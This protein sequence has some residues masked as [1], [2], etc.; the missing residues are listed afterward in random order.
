MRTHTTCFLIAFLMIGFGILPEALAQDESFNVGLVEGNAKLRPIGDYLWRTPSRGQS[1]DAGDRLRVRN[2]RLEVLFPQ[3]LVRMEETGEMEIPV[4]LTEGIPEPWADDVML[5]IGEYT[6]QHR[7]E[8]SWKIKTLFAEIEPQSTTTEFQIRQTQE[9]MEIQ[10]LSG[11]IAIQPLRKTLIAPLTAKSG[12][13][14]FIT[15]RDVRLSPF[16]S[17]LIAF[18]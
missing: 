15:G 2:G 14:A 9:G 13:T 10:I 3:G 1:L 16:D 7:G 4:D 11:S 17:S 8:R 6:L 12:Q 18:H 5:Y